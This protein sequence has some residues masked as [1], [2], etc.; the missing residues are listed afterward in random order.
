MFSWTPTY[1]YKLK[2]NKQSLIPCN[3][4]VRSIDGSTLRCSGWLPM[5]FTIDNHTT[6]QY[7]CEKVDRIYISPKGYTELN[8]LPETFLYP[9]SI[10]IS[11]VDTLLSNLPQPPEKLPFEPTEKNV[12]KLKQYLLQQFSKTTFNRDRPFPSMDTKCTHPYST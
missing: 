1:K 5:T 7:I 8:I 10:T 4:L 2:V 12:P 9:M 11:S 6:T 3:K